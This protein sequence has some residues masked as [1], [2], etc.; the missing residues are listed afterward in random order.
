VGGHGKEKARNA[1]TAPTR[2]EGLLQFSFFLK[3]TSRLTSYDL[4]WFLRA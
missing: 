4:Q 3:S 2:F 1:K